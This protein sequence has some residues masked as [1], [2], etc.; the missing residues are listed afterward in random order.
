MKKIYR[1]FVS[2]TKQD[3]EKE[4]EKVNQTILRKKHHVLCMETFNSANCPPW[5][6]CKETIDQADYFVLI[7]S[8]KYGSINPNTG[9]SYCEDE[10]YYAKSRGIPILAFLIDESIDLPSSKV[11]S[12]K[13]KLCLEKFKNEIKHDRDIAYLEWKN[14]DELANFV[15][16]SLDEAFERTER[17]GLI[18][19]FK[20]NNEIATYDKFDLDS[21]LL[22][23]R[24]G[25]SVYITGITVN[26][27]W[28][29]KNIFKKILDNDVT[30]N[31]LVEKDDEILLKM[32]DFFYNIHNGNDQFEYNKKEVYQ[33][34]YNLRQ[35]SNFKEYYKN[36]LINVRS[37]TSIITTSCIGV[38]IDKDCGQ[39]Q[40]VFYQYGTMTEECPAVMLKCSDVIGKTIGMATINMWNDG[41]PIQL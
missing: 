32:C 15:S 40:A 39:I 5:E 10:F 26:S 20:I 29:K 34:I 17:E 8:Q 31:I 14:A 23:T 7:L 2:S 9:N 35:L 13:S 12:G 25:S 27:V 18:P 1:I 38:D 4:R 36:G 33:S 41:I 24:K 37:A 21:M 28:S 22:S 19:A 6:L 11:D 16:T 3:L 30:L